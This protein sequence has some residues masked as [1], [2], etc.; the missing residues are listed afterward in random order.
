[1]A[2]PIE[3]QHNWAANQWDWPLQHH[4][5]VVHVHNDKDR[6]EVGLEVH[7][8]TPKEIEVKCMNDQLVVHARHEERTDKHGTVTREIHLTYH[9]PPDVDAS[10]L[11]STLTG[12]GIL[13]ITA[14]KKK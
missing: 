12:K 7:F 10:T 11:K 3:V 13:H 9:L 8:F 6:F 4:D 14:N 1:M 5:G 2:Q